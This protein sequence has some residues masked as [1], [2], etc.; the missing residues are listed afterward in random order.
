MLYAEHMLQRFDTLGREGAVLK[1]LDRPLPANLASIYKGLFEECQRRT[2]S[3][4]HEMVNKL[5]TWTA[6]S[7]RPLLLA[8]VESLVKFYNDGEDFDLGEIPEPFAKF[9]R[10]G[11]PG[12]DAEARAKAQSE[13]EVY[14]TEV[15]N[16]EK[17]QDN[18][19]PDN[20]YNDGVLPVKFKE[21]SMRGFFQQGPEKPAEGLPEGSTET[22]DNS[23]WLP[24][25]AHRHIFLTA[26]K[27]ARPAEN[28][29]MVLNEG[30]REYATQFLLS[31]WQE[32]D[33]VQH[34][35]EENAEVMV[36]F[37]DAFSNKHGYVV[38]LEKIGPKFDEKFH[39]LF[40]WRVPQFAWQAAN[41][42][43]DSLSEEVADWWVEFFDTP[44]KC[45][46]QLAKSFIQELCKCVYI[47]RP[48][49]LYQHAR[50]ALK[51]VSPFLKSPRELELMVYLG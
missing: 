8:E 42:A 21:R 24:S 3:K 50:E 15:Q 29:T 17:T 4:H 45:M 16:L 33:P 39:D 1:N 40:F 41:T 51:N 11:D 12:V 43:K 27:M 36:A 35:P 37:Y 44:R 20:V 13:S 19:N 7:F 5:L 14:D 46:L 38:M 26:A 25:A 2:P 22:S 48:V 31:H 9:I 23:R 32:I 30:L 10:V 34:S 6:W 18:S 49:T 47:D 28:D